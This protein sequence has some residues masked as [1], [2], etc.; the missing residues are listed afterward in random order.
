MALLCILF[1]ANLGGPALWDPDEGRH[2]EIARE[3]LVTNNWLTP[4]LGFEPYH[5]KPMGFYWAVATSFRLFGLQEWAARLPSALAAVLTVLAVVLWTRRYVG[6]TEGMVAGVILATAGEFLVLGR[7]VLIDMTFCFWLS[8]A[9]LFGG[10]WLLEGARHGWPP[11]P[12]WICVALAILVKGPVALLLVGAPMVIWVVG[13]RRWAEIFHVRLGLGL[14][15]VVVIAGSWY[16]AAWVRSPAY[17]AEFLYHHNVARFVSGNPGHPGN[18]LF[19]G[20]VLPAVFLPWSVFWLAALPGAWKRMAGGDLALLYAGL[21][22]LVVVVFF[23]LS[24][25]K[26]PTYVLP[27]FPPLAILTATGLV[28]SLRNRSRSRWERRAWCAAAWGLCGALILVPLGGFALLR[29]VG[30]KLLAQESLLMATLLVPVTLVG[31]PVIRSG[32]ASRILVWAVIVTVLAEVGF[33][34]IVAPALGSRYSL[35]NAAALLGSVPA[36]QRLYAWKAITHTLMFYARAPVHR[37]ESAEVAAAVLAEGG[38]AVLT[39]EREL[40]EL[41]SHLSHPVYVWWRGENRKVLLGPLSHPS[42][43]GTELS[44]EPS[45]AR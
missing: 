8:A 6:A 35:R 43:G 31:I 24:R 10:A 23:S 17:V 15:L 41:R 39:K 27:A 20:Y 4:T 42:I 44:P 28:A 9:A 1:F 7:Y 16:L 32:R 18:P 25:A 21:W 19:Y 29:S 3:A 45:C 14:V 12:L 36:V 34:G 2:A 11:W 26:F 22:A 40:P 30:E 5:H 38:A 13:T 37:V 33:Y